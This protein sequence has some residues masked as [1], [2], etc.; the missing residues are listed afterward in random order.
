MDWR[1]FCV[2]LDLRLA[3]ISTLS[4]KAG[5]KIGAAGRAVVDES[6]FHEQRLVALRVRGLDDVTREAV[7]RAFWAAAS[8]MLD[9]STPVKFGAT[10]TTDIAT[11]F[12]SKQP[13]ASS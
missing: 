8:P 9:A 12:Q 2:R 13:G 10:T 11:F 1:N 5:G 4:I 3:K 7:S 6:S